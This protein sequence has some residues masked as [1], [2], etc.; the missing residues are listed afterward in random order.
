M[1]PSAGVEQWHIQH[2]DI[3]SF[4]FGD[5]LPLLQDLFVIPAQAVDGMQIEDIALLQLLHHPQITGALKAT[6]RLFVHKDVFL[7]HAA[8]LH[9]IQLTVFILFP[10]GYPHVS[11]LFSHTVTSRCFGE[12]Q[13]KRQAIILSHSHCKAVSVLGKHPFVWFFLIFIVQRRFQERVD[14][15]LRKTVFT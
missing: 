8:L 12:K 9:G 15:F 3:Y 10:G 13:M 14:V 6:A 2:D 11:I 5:D 4:F 7:L 1:F